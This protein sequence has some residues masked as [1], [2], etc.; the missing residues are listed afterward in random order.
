[1]LV[2]GDVTGPVVALVITVLLAVVAAALAFTYHLAF[3]EDERIRA[4]V[5][6]GQPS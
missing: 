6:A 1:M 3:A 2:M 4:T 5:E